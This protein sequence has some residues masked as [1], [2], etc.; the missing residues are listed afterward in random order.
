M[1][2]VIALGRTLPT[3]CG[4][5]YWGIQVQM[6]VALTPGILTSGDLMSVNTMAT[7]AYMLAKGVH[8]PI[9]QVSQY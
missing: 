4:M 1:S 3:G 2:S 9:L 8:D 7:T 5:I 6:M